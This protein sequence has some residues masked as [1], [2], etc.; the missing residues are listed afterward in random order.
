VDNDAFYEYDSANPTFKTVSDTATKLANKI[1]D[2]MEAEA[3][4]PSYFHYR[5]KARPTPQQNDGEN[6]GVFVCAVAEKL[7]E[8]YQANPATAF[9]RFTEAEENEIENRITPIRQWLYSKLGDYNPN[10]YNYEE[11]AVEDV[12]IR[13]QSLLGMVGPGKEGETE[14]EK[15]DR[16]GRII[17]TNIFG[18]DRNRN[19][20]SPVARYILDHAGIMNLTN[21][22]QAI[23]LVKKIDALANDTDNEVRNLLLK[24]EP[25]VGKK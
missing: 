10:F 8:K 12:F 23:T 3:V 25:G 20:I 1:I 5:I 4:F 24:Y 2:S 21:N 15:K 14:Q 18:A 22:Q 9:D 19:E 16:I 6:C 11:V 17:H 7:V 13:K